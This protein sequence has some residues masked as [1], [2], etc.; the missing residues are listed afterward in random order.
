MYKLFLALLL[1][2]STQPAVAGKFLNRAAS[3]EPRRP[4][5]NPALP[6]PQSET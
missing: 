1:V 4:Q 6:R 3:N 2:A 5:T